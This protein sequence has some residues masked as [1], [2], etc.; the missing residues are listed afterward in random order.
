MGEVLPLPEE[1]TEQTGYSGK[2]RTVGATLTAM[3]VPAWST[4]SDSVAPGIYHDG[5]LGF[6]TLCSVCGAQLVTSEGASAVEHDEPCGV[7][8]LA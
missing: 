7:E 5:A 8:R 3:G 6:L 2:H 4:S 1:F